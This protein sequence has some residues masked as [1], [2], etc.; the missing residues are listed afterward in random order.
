VRFAHPL[1]SY[2]KQMQKGRQYLISNNIVLATLLHLSRAVRRAATLRR[3][4]RRAT[5]RTFHYRRD[6][7]RF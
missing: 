6:T 1:D 4:A 7:C 3:V 2:M 5:V